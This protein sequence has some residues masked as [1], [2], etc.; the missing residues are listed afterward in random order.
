MD[1]NGKELCLD[2]C[3]L[4]KTLITGQKQENNV[5]LHHK[6]GHRIPVIVRTSPIYDEKGNISGVLEMF[7]DS[8]Y[9]HDLYQENRRLLDLTVKDELTRAYNRRFVDYQ[10]K[11]LVSFDK[12]LVLSI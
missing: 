9:K 10:I 7:T 2:G 11:S 3:P 4:E 1:D 6:K 8:R 12:H 5:Y